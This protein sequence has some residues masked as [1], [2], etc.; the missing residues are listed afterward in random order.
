[1][2]PDTVFLEAEMSIDHSH[3]PDAIAQ[4]LSEG[5]KVNYLRDWIYGGID[6]AVTT[7][8]I[9]AGVVGADL[10]AAVVLILGFANLL[11]DGFS[12]A[13]SN[14]AGTKAD[15]DDYERLKTIELRHIRN[16]PEGEREE[17]RQ[18]YRAKGFDGDEL[19]EMVELITRHE[20]VWLDTMLSEEYGLSSVRRSPVMA[21]L[22]TFT[23]FV[24]CGSIPLIPF[25]FVLPNS[26]TLATAMTAVVFVVIGAAK[27]RW[28]LQ[29]WWWSALETFVIGM[30]AAGIAFGVGALLGGLTG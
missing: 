19:E 15:K 14:Y 20:D 30:V 10:S 5:P 27:S 21:A 9:V 2:S 23:A 13:A 16:H 3:T 22:A 28:S 11:A 7:F 24:I 1:V 25:I 18:I 26:A 12:M 8:A 29:K 4:R 17:I 6:G